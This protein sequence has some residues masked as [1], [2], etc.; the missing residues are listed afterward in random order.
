LKRKSDFAS[1]T[2]QNK[3]GREQNLNL[4]QTLGPTFLSGK[5][6]EIF[7]ENAAKNGYME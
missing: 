1:E 2:A 3:I 7:E 6:I 4:V 5:T